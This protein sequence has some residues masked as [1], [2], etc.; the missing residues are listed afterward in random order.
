M[1]TCPRSPSWGA[2]QVKA[3]VALSQVLCTSLSHPPLPPHPS[4]RRSAAGGGQGKADDLSQQI[5]GLELFLISSLTNRK[6]LSLSREGRAEAQR[7]LVSKRPSLGPR[8]A[9]SAG[10][11]LR[12]L[13]DLTE[14]SRGAQS[15]FPLL[16]PVK[17]KWQACCL[18][19]SS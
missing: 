12:S 11:R 6:L 5:P 1:V 3:C 14:P 10:W 19:R 9:L 16:L 15:A 4:L 7:L 18:L 2:I 8:T 13:E 17:G